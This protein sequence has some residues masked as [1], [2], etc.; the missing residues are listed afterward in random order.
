MAFF[1]SNYTR[2]ASNPSAVA[3]SFSSDIPADYT[4][5]VAAKLA[6]TGELLETYH[7]REIDHDAYEAAYIALLGERGVT[8]ESLAAE[9]A[10]GTI[11]I[12]YD[13]EDGE[14]GDGDA[15][16]G[17]TSICHRVFL[18]KWLSEAGVTTTEI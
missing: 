14:S 17:D 2:N 4:G 6:P 18:A 3:I 15:D 11:F 1:T 5:A 7:D 13:Y 16:N 12:C 9:F 10:D 8:P